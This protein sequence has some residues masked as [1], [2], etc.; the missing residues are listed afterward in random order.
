[1]SDENQGKLSRYRSF[2]KKLIATHISLI[3]EPA[4]EGLL[5]KAIMDSKAGSIRGQRTLDEGGSETSVRAAPNVKQL[6]VSP[7][8]SERIILPTTDETEQSRATR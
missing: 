3:V 6:V 2:C 1:M 7:V 8:T 5:T 4:S